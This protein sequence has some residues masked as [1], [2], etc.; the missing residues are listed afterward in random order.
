MSWNP[1]RGDSR[2]GASRVAAPPRGDRDSVGGVDDEGPEGLPPLG[3]RTAAALSI[4]AA[5]VAG[6][7]LA[8]RELG[9]RLLP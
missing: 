5:L 2:I 4:W 1:R 6:L 7:Y 8:V 3:A 9:L